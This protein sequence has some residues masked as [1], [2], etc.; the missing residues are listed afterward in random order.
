MVV[1]SWL[2]G[3]GWKLRMRLGEVRTLEVIGRR[4][5]LMGAWKRYHIIIIIYLGIEIKKT[6]AFIC[7]T[8]ILF[9]LVILIEPRL[10]NHITACFPY[11]R[12]CRPSVPRV[13]LPHQ[14]NV[15]GRRHLFTMMCG[16]VSVLAPG[17]VIQMRL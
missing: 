1:T 12:S 11:S 3:R 6:R 9:Y 14:S 2:S 15:T 8:Q 7:P 10:D 4:C 13:F 16:C 5:S 17:M